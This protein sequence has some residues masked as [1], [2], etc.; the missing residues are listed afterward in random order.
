VFTGRWIHPFLSARGEGNN[1]LRNLTHEHTLI[2][3]M[4]DV[5]VLLVFC[6]TL[7]NGC[8]HGNRKDKT[9]YR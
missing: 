3:E 7:T 8:E 4:A 2:S 1:P 5:F 6:P 9:K